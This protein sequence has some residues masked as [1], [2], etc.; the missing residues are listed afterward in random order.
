MLPLLTSVVLLIPYT[1]NLTTSL[2]GELA[3]YIGFTIFVQFTANYG[4]DNFVGIQHFRYKKDQQGMNHFVGSVV[5]ALLLWGGA[6]FLAFTAIGH[7]LFEW[8]FRSKL[9]FWP[10]GLMCVATGIFNAFFRSYINFLFYRDK[11]IRHLTFNLFNF[12]VTVAICTIG[13]YRYPEELTGPIWGRL[14]S[15]GLIFLLALIFF[16]R[17]Y[18]IYFKW[19]YLE[20]IHRFCFPVYLYLLLGWGVFYI[21][22]LVINFFSSSADVGIFDFA[23]KCVLLVDVTQTAIS[24]TINPRIYQIWTDND[25]DRSTVG[26]NRF[27][28]V[29][30]MVG[31]LFIAINILILPLVIELFVRNES[32]HAVFEYL[33][34][35]ALAFGFR[36]LTNTYYN[37]LMFFKR[38]GA[39]PRSLGLSSL[40]QLISCVVLMQFFGLWGA[41]W[42]FFLSK[43]SLVLFTWLEARKVFEFKLNMYKM[44]W[45]P[46]SYMAM[47]IILVQMINDYYLMAGIQLVIAGLLTVVVYRKDFSSYRLLLR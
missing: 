20:G 7:V 23:L 18:G 17:E 10:Y 13:V 43:A 21:N 14:L 44:L 11:P 34:I 40:I 36:M 5:G 15:G 32:Y 41:I 4:V 16:I 46:L 12:I 30:S 3:L 47:V 25:L 22:T 24:Q 19:K 35:L 38:T 6:V 27:H 9:A 31:I 37:P 28:H 1:E 8:L 26:E 2:Y 33:P 29:F 39:L 45:L 42:S